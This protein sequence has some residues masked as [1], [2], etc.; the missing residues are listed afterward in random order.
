M[1]FK[2]HFLFLTLIG[3]LLNVHIANACSC[4]GTCT[5]GGSYEGA[6]VVVIAR[7]VS[8]EKAEPGAGYGG[9]RSTKMIVEKVFKGDLKA[10]DEMTF[11]QG[12]GMDCI[13]GFDQQSVG[14]RFLFYLG[15]PEKASKMWY[16]G[17]C[18][19]SREVQG[20]EEATDDLLYLNRL[21]EVRGKTR[22]SGTIRFINGADVNVE[23]RTIRII[24]GDKSYEVKTNKSGVYEIYDLPAGKYLIEPE[25][26]TGWKLSEFWPRYSLLLHD[27]EK[28]PNKIPVVLADKGHV[29]LDIEYLIDN[30]IRGKVYDPNGNP[31]QGVCIGV[32]EQGENRAA[33]I[34]DCTK[35]DGS[36]AI[37]T[38]VRGSYVLVVNSGGKISS[39]EPFRTFYYP[40]VFEREKAVAIAI[41]EGEI[42]E[43]V[44]IYAPKTEETITIE[45]TLLYSDG[46]PAVGAGAFV[47]FKAERTKDNIEGDANAKPDPKGRFSIKILKGLKGRLYG[48]MYAYV[49]EF[50][51]CPQLDSML[52]KTGQSVVTP[53]IEVQAES[54]LSDV[55][56]RYP[57]PSCKRAR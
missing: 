37:T 43:G 52:E 19:R 3:L 36:F 32:Q 33:G 51:N 25:V 53:V 24:G 49:G 1:S 14:R 44:N 6:S 31:M 7:A 28:L 17:V 38:L 30:A 41:R 56:L 50:E 26:P 13:W 27:Q 15:P 54:D 12:A 55:E 48:E 42:L 22:I 2:H 47:Q 46:K 29:S 8:V 5:V 11:G 4:M 21:R 9:I 23:G 20:S 18:G 57:F 10:G 34:L 40:N 45:G 16:V 39:R 35:E